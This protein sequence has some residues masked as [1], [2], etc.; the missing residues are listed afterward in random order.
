MRA[1]PNLVAKYSENIA[2]KPAEY[3]EPVLEDEH[4][5][6]RGAVNFLPRTLKI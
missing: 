3:V 6:S 2:L 4:V 5:Y 1:T